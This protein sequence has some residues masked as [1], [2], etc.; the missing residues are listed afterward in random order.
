MKKNNGMVGGWNT[1]VIHHTEK[2][3]EKED[4]LCLVG[5]KVRLSSGEEV[6]HKI[7]MSKKE[8]EKVKN[9]KGSRYSLLHENLSICN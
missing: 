8:Y 7:Y 4:K 1:R 3:P 2:E 6:T 5:L 9:Q